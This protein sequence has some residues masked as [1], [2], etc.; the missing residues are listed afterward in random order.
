MTEHGRDCSR[1]V[2]HFTDHLEVLGRGQDDPKSGANEGVVVD[3]QHADGHSLSPSP[4]ELR[5]DDEV[6]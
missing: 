4:G 6:A 2:A 3:Q 5:V 1:T